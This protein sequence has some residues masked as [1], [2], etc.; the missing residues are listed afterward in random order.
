MH[1]QSRRANSVT[2]ILLK[3]MTLTFETLIYLTC[4]R[5]ECGFVNKPVETI[6]KVYF[7]TILESSHPCTNEDQTLTQYCIV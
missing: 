2:I 4:R 1:V 7:P 6:E 5:W 3:V